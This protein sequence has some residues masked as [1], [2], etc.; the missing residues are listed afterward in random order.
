MFCSHAGHKYEL[1]QFE[2]EAELKRCTTLSGKRDTHLFPEIESVIARKTR[3][4]SRL[5]TVSYKYH[6]TETPFYGFEVCHLYF[7]QN[8]FC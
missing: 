2:Y 6:F 8:S 4:R 7:F 5:K 1:L 3:R